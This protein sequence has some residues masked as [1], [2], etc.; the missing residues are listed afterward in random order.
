[1]SGA[2]S[3]LEILT[4]EQIEEARDHVIAKHN[5]EYSVTY[6]K[7]IE[8]RAWDLPWPDPRR[9]LWA[10][11][12]GFAFLLGDYPACLTAAEGETP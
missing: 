4:S 12:E 8:M 3:N 1:M 11:I 7:L 10:D 9:L 5:A 6:Q 2:K